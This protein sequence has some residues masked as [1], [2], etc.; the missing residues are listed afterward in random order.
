MMA[1]GGSKLRLDTLPGARKPSDVPRPLTL[2]VPAI[3]LAPLPVHAQAPPS[4]GLWRVAA[5]ALARPA[6]LQRGATG[7]F[8]N[9]GATGSTDSISGLRVGAQVMQTSNILGISG[10]L[11]GASLPLTNRIRAGAVLGRMQVRD[12]VRTTTSPDVEAG[13]IPVYEQFA[14]VGVSMGPSWIQVGATVLLHDARFDVLNDGGLTVDLGIRLA[15]WP[16]LHIAAATHLLPVDLATEPSTDYFAAVEYVAAERL[17]LPGIHAALLARYGFALRASGDPEH[18]LGFGAVFGQRVLVD[19]SLTAES[20]Y[21]GRE[22]RP[23]VGVGLRFGAYLVSLAHGF[24]INDLGGTFRIGLD[25][26]P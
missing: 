1:K 3:L 22:W 25:I 4:A 15:P 18:T 16:R 2:L 26:E 8:W 21:G 17:E 24:S 13:S 19:A 10:F 11:L 20:G 12:L 7:T 6:P 5:G 23:A 14:G 9:P